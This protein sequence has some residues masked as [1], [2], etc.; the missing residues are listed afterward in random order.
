MVKE[1][2]QQSEKTIYRMANKTANHISNK[3]LIYKIIKNSYNSIA[4]NI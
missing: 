2:N 1:K 3:G 4:K